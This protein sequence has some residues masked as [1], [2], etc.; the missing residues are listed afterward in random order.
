[1]RHPDLSVGVLVDRQ[2]VDHPDG[3]AAQP[4]Q[5]LDDLALKFVRSADSH[6]FWLDGCRHALPSWDNPGTLGLVAV[7]PRGPIGPRPDRRPRPARPWARPV[8]GGLVPAARPSDGSAGSDW[9]GFARSGSPPAGVRAPR[10]PGLAARGRRRAA[11][12][13]PAR[14]LRRRGWAVLHDLAIP[15]WPANIDH[16]AIG[17]GGVPVIDSKHYRGRLRLDR[18]GMVWHGRHLLVSAPRRVHNQIA[19]LDASQEGPELSGPVGHAPPAGLG[20]G[21]AKHLGVAPLWRTGLVARS[22]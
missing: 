17:P 11:H 21:T 18:N 2:G 7:D 22:G 4:F 16:L 6:R 3:V 15:G 8:A 10:H 5:L 20:I 13:P 12:R 1:M 9:P 19:R 14:P